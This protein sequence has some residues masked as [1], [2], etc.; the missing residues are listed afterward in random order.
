MDEKNSIVENWDKIKEVVR[1]ENEI[2]DV[3]FETWIAPMEIFSVENET[4]KIVTPGETQRGVEILSNKYKLAFEIAISEV[5]NKRYT[6]L[7][8]TE[9]DAKTANPSSDKSLSENLKLETENIQRSNLNPKYTFDTFVV[10]PNNRLAHSAALAVAEDPGFVYNPLF[11]Y[12]GP[13]LGKTHLMHSIGHY[14]IRKNPNK[15]IR[16]VTSETFTNEVIE[17]IQLGGTQGMSKFREKYRT[18]DVLLLD[19]VQFIIGKESTQNE[20]FNTFNELHAQNKAIILSSD[21]PP[22][23][24]ETLEERLR[25]RFDWGLTV[26]INPPDYETRMA[27]LRRYAKNIGVSIDDEIVQYVASNIKSNIR[28]L[29]GALNKIVALHKLDNREITMFTAEQAIIAQ[30]SIWQS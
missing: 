25:S 22:K 8:I 29:E 20:F 24:M 4:I 17:T 26:D 9:D 1:T 16:Y 30:Y 13:G 11:L 5:M 2:L 15:N 18:V 10:G 7:F 27:I 12:G 14:I 19:D 3:P 21:K 28:E 6:V 23:D